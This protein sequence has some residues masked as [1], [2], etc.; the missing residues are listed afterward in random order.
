MKLSRRYASITAENE[1]SL[2]RDQSDSRSREA[3][4]VLVDAGTGLDVADLLGPADDLVAVCLTHAHADH[5][6]SLG[7]CVR[8]GA[9]V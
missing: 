7:E 1:L 5:C 4:R 2:L 3:S 9:T 8:A 6:Q